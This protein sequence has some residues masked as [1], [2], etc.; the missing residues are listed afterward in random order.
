[1]AKNTPV[2]ETAADRDRFID[3]AV[4]DFLN[5]R[6]G[7]AGPLRNV[8]A[9]AFVSSELSQNNRRP[10]STEECA[11][12]DGAAADKLRRRFGGS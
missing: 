7:A 4:T 10:L 3:S 8:T 12:V 5:A 1:M 2:I 9:T 6:T 11:A